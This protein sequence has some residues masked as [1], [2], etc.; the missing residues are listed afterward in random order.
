[1]SM[2]NSVNVWLYCMV[3]YGV[4][5]YDVVLWCGV[6]WDSVIWCVCVGECKHVYVYAWRLKGGMQFILPLVSA[7]LC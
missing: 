5:W 7:F 1:M 3:W 2:K 4:V 6:V